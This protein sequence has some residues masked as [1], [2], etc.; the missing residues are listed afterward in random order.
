MAESSGAIKDAKKSWKLIRAKK[1]RV[2]SRNISRQDLGKFMIPSLL[3]QGS[4]TDQ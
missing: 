3:F 4:E 2:K 1:R